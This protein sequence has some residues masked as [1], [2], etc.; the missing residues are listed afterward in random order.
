MMMMM[1]MMTVVV[2]REPKLNQIS[3]KNLTQHYSWEENSLLS[4]KMAASCYL[5]ASCRESWQQS[6]AAVERTRLRVLSS[7][8]LS[9][10]VA[11]GW[12]Q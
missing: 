12:K 10:P 6:S 4:A 2:V 9:P 1:M 7:S 5:A 3:G 11:Q 8:F